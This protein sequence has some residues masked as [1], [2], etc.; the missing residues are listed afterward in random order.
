[1]ILSNNRGKGLHASQKNKSLKI[2]IT[3]SSIN[4]IF[5]FYSKEKK[6][7]NKLI[8]SSKKEPVTNKDEMHA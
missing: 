6:I 3:V 7:D 4:F 2:I 5:Y 8:A 1:M